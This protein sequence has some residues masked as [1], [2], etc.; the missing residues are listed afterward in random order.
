MDCI[1]YTYI[2]HYNENLLFEKEMTVAQGVT[3]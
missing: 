3:E 1:H 2:N